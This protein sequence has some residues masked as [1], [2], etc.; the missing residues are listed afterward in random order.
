M[1]NSLFS[2][3][4]QTVYGNSVKGKQIHFQGT[5]GYRIICLIIQLL[6]YQ[7]TPLCPVTPIQVS[8]TYCL[9][10]MLRLNTL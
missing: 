2:I 6:N 7:L 5:E 4:K 8:I 9:G 1:V 10:Y 3:R